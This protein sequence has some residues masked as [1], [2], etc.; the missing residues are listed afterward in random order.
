MPVQNIAIVGATGGIGRALVELYRAQ[1]AQVWALSRQAPMQDQ[2]S[3][4]LMLDLCE[5]ESIK[6][7]VSQLPA[8][9]DA[10][11]VATGFLHDQ[12]TQ[13]EKA[14]RMMRAEHF[15]KAFAINTIGPSLVLQH[16]VAHLGRNS[17][18]KLAALTARVGSISDNRL[19]G[20]HA[21]RASKAAL[22]MLIKNMAIE[23]RRTHPN[24][25]LLGLHPGTVDTKLS[26]PFQSNVP[27]DKLFTPE[28][29][30]AQ[31]I[32]VMRTRGPQDTGKIFDW[33]NQ[34]IM[35]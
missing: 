34:E 3:Q 13:P 9:L 23:C 21:Y 14:I 11:V 28:F 19:G 12:T 1:G 17:H 18:A 16:V 24:L 5:P 8:R 30:A 33:N 26:K 35:P 4:C 32:Q 20:W 31:L 27:E 6:H 7:A 22:N 25:T 2:D 29:S 10:V 15:H